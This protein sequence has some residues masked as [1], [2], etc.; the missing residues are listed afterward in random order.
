MHNG[1]TPPGALDC[2]AV[3]CAAAEMTSAWRYIGSVAVPVVEEGKIYS[4]I[5]AHSIPVGARM[6]HPDFLGSQ[7]T[8]VGRCS[9]DPVV[10]SHS[11]AFIEIGAMRSNS[12]EQ[13]LRH[14]VKRVNWRLVWGGASSRRSA[15]R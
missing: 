8:I 1:R 12:E 7:M 6:C 3:F 2:F 14:D 4:L 9:R 15:S 5:V 10:E 13:L 11:G